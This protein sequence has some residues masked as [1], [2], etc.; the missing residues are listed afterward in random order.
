MARLM[1]GA[2]DR[3][4][5]TTTRRGEAGFRVVG[6]LLLVIP[7][8]PVAAMFGPYADARGSCGPV[9]WVLGTGIVLAGAWLAG[10]LTPPRLLRA[11]R[12]RGRALAARLRPAALPLVL[13]AA[14]VALVILSVVVFRCRPVMVD[15]I[16]QLFQAR[17]FAAGTVKAPPPA[18]AEFFTT[19]HLI[20]DEHGWYAQYPPGHS[21]LLTLGLWGGA[22]WVVPI[23][24][25][26]G[27]IVVTVAFARRVYGETVAGVTAALF[28]LSP[29]FLLMGASFMNHPPTLFF[30]SLA[31]LAFVRWEETRGA[32]WPLLWGAALGA[33]FL[34]RPVCAF[35]TGGA[36][37][38]FA[39]PEVVR[40]RRAAG[41][42]LA[43]AGVGGLAG[44]VLRFTRAC[45]GDPFLPWYVKLLRASSGLR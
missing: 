7:F 1:A 27:T 17:I 30:V 14:G 19:Q 36:M 5:V 28:L 45:T 9:D 39:L 22:P 29:F 4:V 6:V 23:L 40:G 24:F 25:S 2:W 15:E 41:V 16:V 43:A 12:R 8:L 21:A 10:V 3:P 20:V 37:A 35:A 11:L 31:L 44:S 38:C 32:R 34:C 33:G 13:A 18:L 42:A 26:L